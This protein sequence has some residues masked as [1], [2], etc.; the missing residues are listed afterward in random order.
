MN[1]LEQKATARK[2]ADEYRL[3]RNKQFSAWEHKEKNEVINHGKE[4]FIRDGVIS[5]EQ[6]FT[7]KVR[8]LFL[9]KEAF[10]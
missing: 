1:E 6:W 8:P 10:I 2:Y 4:I 3:N 7:Q 5:P 9:L